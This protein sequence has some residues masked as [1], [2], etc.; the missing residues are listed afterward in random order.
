MTDVVS[1]Y[2][3]MK[4][5]TR[6]PEALVRERGILG[7]EAVQS[8]LRDTGSR[9]FSQAKACFEMTGVVSTFEMTGVVVPEIRLS[10]VNQPLYIV[11]P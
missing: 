1:F 5:V 8:R 2:V 10:L 3:I 7:K 6:H 4:R 9:D 11:P